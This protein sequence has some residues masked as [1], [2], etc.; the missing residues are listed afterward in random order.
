M[1]NDGCGRLAASR[2]PGGVTPRRSGNK[3]PEIAPGAFVSQSQLNAWVDRVD[4]RAPDRY[5]VAKAIAIAIRRRARPGTAI[6]V[7]R[8]SHLTGLPWKHVLAVISDL[9]NAGKLRF[10]KTGRDLESRFLF[11]ITTASEEEAWARMQRSPRTAPA[12]KMPSL[13][14]RSA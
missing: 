13:W 10:T 7:R 2:S 14:P 12:T 8:L 9:R 3:S 11:T 1:T 4:G 5:L 6:D